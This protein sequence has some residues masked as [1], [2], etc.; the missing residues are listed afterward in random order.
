M[1]TPHRTR[2][3]PRVFNRG[4]AVHAYWVRR[5]V[6]FEAIDPTGR[7]LGRV[8]AVERDRNE[9]VLARRFRRQ[10]VPAV[11][12]QSV[13]PTDEIVLVGDPASPAEDGASAGEET[14]AWFDLVASLPPDAV[15]SPVDAIPRDA[16]Q[17]RW[18]S[19]RHG[20]G[21]TS[22]ALRERRRYVADRAREAIIALRR[23][24]A[25]A[26]RWCAQAVDPDSEASRT[27]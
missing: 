15:A 16:P 9:L 8:H 1:A 3:L 13:W 5:C 17:R 11:A 12:V 26:L 2:P 6:G 19:V 23:G 20:I 27:P 25:A 14:L 24:T 21:S 7:P 22:S 10:N 4:S 18:Q